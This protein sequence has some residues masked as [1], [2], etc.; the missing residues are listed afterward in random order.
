M[1]QAFSVFPNPVHD[2]LTVRLSATTNERATLFLLDHQGRLVHEAAL[3]ANAGARDVLLDLSALA[4]G[5]YTLRLVMDGE[6]FVQGLVK[7]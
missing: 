5:L 6:V 4:N 7:Q 1:Q 3:Q 2:R